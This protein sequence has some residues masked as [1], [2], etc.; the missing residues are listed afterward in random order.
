MDIVITY[1]DGN[2]VEWKKDYEKYADEPVMQKRFRDWGTLKYLLR[3]IECKMPFVR[4]V[5]LV[6]SH[7]TQVPDWVNQDV[8]KVVLQDRKSVV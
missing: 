1:V 5:Y 4:N 6:V 2:D 7:S 3:G 8:L